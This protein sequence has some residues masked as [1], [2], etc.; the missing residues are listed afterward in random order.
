MPTPDDKPR[1]ALNRLDEEL[2]AFEKTRVK[3]ATPLG[4]IGSV[5]GGY[6]I[7]AEL[8]GGVGAG[9]GAGWLVDLFAHTAPW[10]WAIGISAG[11]GFGLYMAAHSAVRMGK[12]AMEKA[13][14]VQSVPFDDDED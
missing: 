14:P 2:S 1:E 9:F 6:R 7:L 5:N 11:A 4:A 3:A 8:I 12:Q 13:G 10:G